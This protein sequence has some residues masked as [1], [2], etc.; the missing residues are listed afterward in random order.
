MWLRYLPRPDIADPYWTQLR[1]MIVRSLK[2]KPILRPWSG[3]VSRC[4]SQLKM[5]P[6][7]FLDENREPLFRDLAEEIYLSDEYPLEDKRTLQAIGVELIGYHDLFKRVKAD[8]ESPSSMTKN[9]LTSQSWHTRS[10][11]MMLDAAKDRL[12]LKS[13]CALKMLPLRDGSWTS[14]AQ[15]GV[16]YPQIGEV[17]I[18][19]DLGL[20]LL[21]PESLFNST[22]RKLFDKLGLESCDP[23]EVKKLIVSKYNK[24]NGVDLASSVSHIHFLF[25]HYPKEEGILPE[26]V[27]LFDA[28]EQPIY[29][30]RVTLGR[31][32]MIVDDLYFDSASKYDVKKLCAKRRDSNGWSSKRVVHII[33][34]AYMDFDGPASL[35]HNLS[36]SAWLQKYAEILPSPRL[37]NRNKPLKPSDLFLWIVEYRRDSVLGILKTHWHTYCESM[38]QEIVA[39]LQR[40]KIVCV[41]G[42]NV[43][44]KDT[45]V[46]LPKLVKIAKDLKVHDRM[47]FMKLPP[48]FE[49]ESVEGWLFL[50]L[51]GVGVA[52]DLNF[53]LQALRA[54]R[55][56][57]NENS[58]RLIVLRVYDAIEERARVDNYKHLR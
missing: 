14:V 55:N 46:P 57:E 21:A 26:T 44:L 19:Q 42:E 39:F 8:L 32:D 7:G 27:V 10:A 52:V 18:P 45:L 13:L 56:L 50:E 31:D 6:K 53:Y 30:V 35:P 16:H 40:V 25:Y 3:G 24:W 1:G 58:M 4:I 22:R 37:V 11:R 9:F 48:E 15:G 12:H 23:M 43:R 49:S 2:D 17:D 28:Q 5:L 54:L 34:P 33:N 36:W 47:R 38:S 20:R 41:N 51:L 29:R